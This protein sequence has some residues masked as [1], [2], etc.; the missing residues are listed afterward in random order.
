MVNKKLKNHYHKPYQVYN[1]KGESR[2]II[3]CDHA[4]N[5]IPPKFKNLGLHKY[6]IYK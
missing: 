6:E 3:L 5:Y 4:S 2:A 1:S